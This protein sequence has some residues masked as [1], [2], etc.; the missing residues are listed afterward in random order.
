M[1]HLHKI[2][3]KYKGREGLKVKGRKEIN[4]TNN[5]NNKAGSLFDYE[6][7]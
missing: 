6:R 2:Q 5:K 7:F 3:L 1:C 4:Q